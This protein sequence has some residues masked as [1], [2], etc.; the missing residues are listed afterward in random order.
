MFAYTKIYCLELFR[1]ASS[2]PHERHAC[3]VYGALL[4]PSEQASLWFG[5]NPENNVVI[6]ASQSVVIIGSSV[7]VF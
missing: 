5:P 4:V 1:R 2:G 6:G 3:V 7:P